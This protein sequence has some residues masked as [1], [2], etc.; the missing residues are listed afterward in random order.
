MKRGDI[1]FADL[2]PTIGHEIK[3]RRPVLIVSNNA[4]NTASDLITI[5]PLTSNI[6]K[7]Y[8][9]EVLLSA[10]ETGL[11]K[12]SKAQCHQVRTISK[13]R[14]ERSKRVGSVGGMLPKIDAALKLHLDL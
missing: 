5:I 13:R 2:D 11:T 10:K 3:K 1:Y 8:P 12:D 6:T 7:V 9:F 4:S 14:I